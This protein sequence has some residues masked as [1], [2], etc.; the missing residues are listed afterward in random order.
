MIRLFDK[1]QEIQ[2]L[3]VSPSALIEEMVKNLNRKSDI[4]C[5]FYETSQDVRDQRNLSLD[6]NNLI[7]FE[8]HMVEKQNQCETY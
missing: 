3:N 4:D 1:Q 7:I 6:Y 8:D 2:T 5:K